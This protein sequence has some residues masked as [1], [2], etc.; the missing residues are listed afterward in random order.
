MPE[1][2]K[3]E[4]LSCPHCKDGCNV[5]NMRPQSCVDFKCEWIKGNTEI[6]PQEIC[7][8]KLPDVP[9][10]LAL[11]R[12]K[13]ALFDNEEQLKEYLEKGIAVVSCYRTVL[14]PGGIT[15]KEVM[16]HVKNAA[17]SMGVI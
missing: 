12:N 13:K 10:V 14:L 7:L 6:D 17:K 3:P 4:G 9:V 1:L 2:N 5:Y 16:D 15:G 8:E 11:T